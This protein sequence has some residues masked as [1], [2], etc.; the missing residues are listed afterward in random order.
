[1]RKDDLPEWAAD[2]LEHQREMGPP[3][4]ADFGAIGIAV[5]IGLTLAVGLG[6]VVLSVA[7]QFGVGLAAWRALGL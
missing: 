6:L 4:Q 7:W 1:M 3:E 5:K 2:R